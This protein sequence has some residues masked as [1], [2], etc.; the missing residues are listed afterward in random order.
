[1]V[2][3]K[4]T[5]DTNARLFIAKPGVTTVDVKTDLYSDAKEHWLSGGVAMGFKF[6]IRSVAGD[7]TSSGFVEPFFFLGDGWRIRPQEADHT[8]V[9]TGNLEL[10]EGETGDLVVPTVGDYTVLVRNALSNK[11]SV[12]NGVSDMDAIAAGVWNRQEA[13]VGAT[14]S[15]GKRVKEKLDAP[16]SSRAVAGDEMVLTADERLAISALVLCRDFNQL[17]EVASKHSLLSAG[18]KL[19]SRFSAKTG[20]TYRTDGVTPHMVQTLVA[21]PTMKPI[22][23]VGPAQ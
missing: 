21:D 23:E 22:A 18:L 9:L 12:L 16:V 8:L 5:V 3:Q 15:I 19:V 4:F 11:A 10:D 13:L 6:P 2:M 17:E 7:P 1:M 14:G 20:T